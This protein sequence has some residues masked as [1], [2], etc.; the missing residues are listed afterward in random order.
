MSLLWKPDVCENERMNKMIGLLDDRA[1]SATVE[2]KS[3]RVSL[4][5]LLGEAGL[6]GGKSRAKWSELKSVAANVREECLSGWD[7][8]LDVQCNTSGWEPSD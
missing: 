4:K 5:Y 8:F 2:L 1:P 6:A 3:A 7:P